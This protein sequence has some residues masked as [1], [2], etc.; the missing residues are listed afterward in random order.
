MYDAFFLTKCS[1]EVKNE[2]LE[3]TGEFPNYKATFKHPPIKLKSTIFIRSVANEEIYLA[4]ASDYTAIQNINKGVN[5]DKLPLSGAQKVIGI[6]NYRFLDDVTIE[7][8]PDGYENTEPVLPK[9]YIDLN[10]DNAPQNVYL[11]NYICNPEYC[12][13]CTGKGVACDLQINQAGNITL[14]TSEE[15]VRQKVLKALLTPLG[16]QPYD[17][18]FGTELNLLI[19]QPIVSDFFRLTINKTISDC[20]A[21]LV[22]NQPST[23]PA[24]ER[25]VCLSGLAIQHNEEEP[26][27]I[28]IKV[29]VTNAKGKDISVYRSIY[30]DETASVVGG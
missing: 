28:N 20:I 22:E 25:I 16:M 17:Q 29:T 30:L 8:Y 18:S 15:K 10:P 24:D 7:F 2:Q 19:G 23:L 4:Q 13:A 11:A 5:I 21:S 27:T 3:I 12:P 14:V 26:D 6:T 1:H 9:N